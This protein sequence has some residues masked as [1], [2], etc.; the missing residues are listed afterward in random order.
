MAVTT[1]SLTTQGIP[2]VTAWI[3]CWPFSSQVCCLPLSRGRRTGAGSCHL[4]SCLELL[5]IHHTV[6][7]DTPPD[8]F[9]LALLSG[10]FYVFLN[11][12]IKSCRQSCEVFNDARV[13]IQI[14]CILFAC[15]DIGFSFH[16]KLRS[17]IV[18]QLFFCL[19]HLL[20]SVGVLSS[21]LV[22]YRW[23][24]GIRLSNL[25]LLGWGW[26]NS[27]FKPHFC[28]LWLSEI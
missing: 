4:P 23:D 18:L 13:R 20:N 1:Q 28:F 14:W 24:K 26:K 3:V 15:S 7:I 8:I 16:L 19:C 9:M 21:V 5:F 12:H 27:G 17:Q 22:G 2:R 10:R 6:L 11:K 25:F